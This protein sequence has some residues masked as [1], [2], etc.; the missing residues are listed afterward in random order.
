MVCNDGGSEYVNI[1]LFCKSTGVSLQIIEARNQKSN[2]KAERM[3][4]TVLNMVH[5][6]VFTSIFPMSL[7]KKLSSV[8]HRSLSAVR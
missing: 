6:M 5:S 2:G 3:L 8:R 1:D 4:K 7:W